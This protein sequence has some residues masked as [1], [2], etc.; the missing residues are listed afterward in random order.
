MDFNIL[1]E[2]WHY[3]KYFLGLVDSSV[4]CDI[5]A[6]LMFYSHEQRFLVKVKTKGAKLTYSVSLVDRFKLSSEQAKEF[7]MY[8]EF[9][10]PVECLVKKYG[11]LPEETVYELSDY[12][13]SIFPHVDGLHREDLILVDEKA[14]I[15]IPLQTDD[16]FDYCGVSE[17][18][19]CIHYE[20]S[21]KEQMSYPERMITRIKG[22]NNDDLLQYEPFFRGKNIILLGTAITEPNRLDYKK[23]VSLYF[24]CDEKYYQIDLESKYGYDTK[25]TSKEAASKEKMKLS[26]ESRTVFYG[27]GK[28]VNVQ[29]FNFINTSYSEL[30]KMWDIEGSKDDFFYNKDQILPEFFLKSEMFAITCKDDIYAEATILI[31]KMV[32][33]KGS[34]KEIRQRRFIEQML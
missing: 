7:C 17:N 14:D 18:S 13:T 33:I 3:K 19:K 2:E 16:V 32:T 20:I 24:K 11:E 8:T 30:E 12:I 15:Y 22:G 1:D 21:L 5:D 31:S 28:P 23:S 9:A 4:G 25:V 34:T 29:E 10:T 27:Y 6:K 26:N